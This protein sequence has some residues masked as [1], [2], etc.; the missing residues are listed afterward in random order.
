M[1][2]PIDAQKTLSGVSY[3]CSEQDLLS[4]AT[5]PRQG[6]RRES[7]ILNRLARLPDGGIGGP[8]Q[9]HKAGF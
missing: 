8:D 5:S 4:H 6:Q 3:P 7:G 2:N 9:V 1:P